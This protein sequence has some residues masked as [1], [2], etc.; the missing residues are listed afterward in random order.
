MNVHQDQG[1][2]RASR[3][4]PVAPPAA[5][6]DRRASLEWADSYRVI[7]GNPKTGMAA[8]FC[9]TMRQLHLRDARAAKEADQ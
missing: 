3:S 5:A 7:R 2:V 4:T 1:G 8:G 6:L 9:K